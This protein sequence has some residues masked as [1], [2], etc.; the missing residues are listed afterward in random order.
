MVRVVAHR[1]V[2]QVEIDIVDTKVL[3]SRI[4][5]LLNALM[6]GVRELAGDLPKNQTRE[7]V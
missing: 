5:T 7:P 2:D 1:P 6:V 4:K 3:Q